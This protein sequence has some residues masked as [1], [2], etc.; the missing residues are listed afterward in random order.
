MLKNL[1]TQVDFLNLT[2]DDIARLTD[3]LD[4]D[5]PED[6]DKYEYL[7]ER[8][9]TI[10]D[11][12]EANS[13]LTNK[14]LAGQ[15]TVKWFKYSYDENINKDKLIE[16]L[17]SEDFGFD[18][19]VGNRISSNISNDIASV[20][21]DGD[22]Y[23]LKVF[24]FDGYKRHNNGIVSKREMIMKNIIVKI[25]VEN[26]WVEIRA[27]D[28]RC[29]KIIRILEVRLGLVNLSGSRILKNYVNINDFKNSL[30]DGFHLNYKAVP[31]ELIKLTEEDGVKI[32]N[33]IAIIDDYFEEK[34]SEI[35]LSRLDELEFDLDGLSL[36]SLLLA[37]VD[38]VGMK[39]RN[40]S[41]ND[42]SNQSL[43]AILKDHLIEDSSYIRFKTT[44]NG[45]QYTMRIGIKTNSIVFKS[46]VTEDVINYIR[47]RVL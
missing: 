35:L 32:A 19:D 18:V 13:I 40:D 34:N 10:E 15:V 45:E 31:S 5:I 26:C 12:Q 7:F 42:M 22:V 6:K 9:N 37:G 43:Y 29:N 47:E 4:I 27:N 30:V 21:C 25:N 14:V 38:S 24:I 17:Q 3:I 41:E 8:I 16:K 28:E 33:M 20:V 44:P 46:S 39:I 1:Y 2:T 36:S 11:N 23:T